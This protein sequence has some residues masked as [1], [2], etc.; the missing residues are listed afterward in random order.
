MFPLPRMLEY[1]N[2]KPHYDAPFLMHA[3]DGFKDL[4][5]TDRIIE[6]V[7]TPKLDT[8]QVLAG[9][10]QSYDFRSGYIRIPVTDM[11]DLNVGK[12]TGDFTIEFYGYITTIGSASSIWFLSDG[13]GTQSGVKTYQ[14][15]LYLQTRTGGANKTYTSIPM[16]QW[17]HYALVQSG[18]TVYWYMNGVLHLTA[19]GRWGN[20]NTPLRIGGYEQPSAGYYD[21]IR[22]SNTALYKG[23][24]TIVPPPYPLI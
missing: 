22:I 21:Q 3:D 8:T 4:S 6:I 5:K 15:Q 24:A 18:T 12:D 7:N 2:I 11:V 1:G 19:P 16:N 23:E 14:G 13:N 9:L 10:K 20:L 17:V